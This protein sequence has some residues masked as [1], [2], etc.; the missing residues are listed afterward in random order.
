MMSN[1]KKCCF[2][3]FTDIFHRFP[4][5]HNYYIFIAV[6]SWNSRAYLNFL[7]SLQ[8]EKREHVRKG[9]QVEAKEIADLDHILTRPNIWYHRR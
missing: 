4:Q 3:C 5:P 9:E 2:I 1:L 8:T 6:I 7:I